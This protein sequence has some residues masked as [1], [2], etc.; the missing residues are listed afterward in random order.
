[1]TKGQFPVGQEIFLFSTVPRPSLRPTQPP[2]KC[3]L[4][5]LSQGIKQLRHEADRS[6]PSSV[7]VKNGGAIHTPHHISS[8]CGA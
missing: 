7:V 6:P 8:W 2:M 3:A 4:G 1:M 5:P